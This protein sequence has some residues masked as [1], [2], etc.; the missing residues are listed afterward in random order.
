MN[1]TGHQRTLARRDEALRHTER[2]LVHGVGSLTE[3]DEV[4]AQARVCR[5]LARAFADPDH[6]PTR[7][8][9][10]GN[11]TFYHPTRVPALG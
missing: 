3:R 8:S 5:G 11:A 1:R 10:S 7:G 2:D 4:V 9:G 6:R